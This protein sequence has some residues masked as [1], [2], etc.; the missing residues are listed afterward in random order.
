MLIKQEFPT[1]KG[2]EVYNL[3]RIGEGI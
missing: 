1:C 3:L 2:V